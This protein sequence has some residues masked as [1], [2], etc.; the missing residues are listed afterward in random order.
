MQDGLDK[1]QATMKV[2]DD[3]HFSTTIRMKGYT[4]SRNTYFTLN[5]RVCGAETISVVSSA[6]QTFV[7]DFEPGS[8]TGMADSVRY[9]DVP[10][11]AFLQYF[12]ISP[13]NDPCTIDEYSLVFTGLLAP[14]T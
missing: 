4:L 9:F 3:S 7:F 11:S 1:D 13:N 5:V 2:I 10:Q 8:T 14:E 6:K 12:S